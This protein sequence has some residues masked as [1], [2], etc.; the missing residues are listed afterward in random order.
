MAMKIRAALLGM[1]V[2][3]SIVLSATAHGWAQEKKKFSFKAPPGLGKYTQNHVIDVRD[4]PGHQ[5][6]IFELRTAYTDVAPEFDGVKVKEAWA[7]GFSDY[8]NGS[9]AATAYNV[10]LMENGDKIYSRT[11]I[12]SHTVTAADGS[13]QLTFRTVQTLTGGTGKFSGIRGVL[14]GGGSSDLKTA[15]VDSGTQGEYWIEK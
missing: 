6:R 2:T 15:V 14:L 5:I 1:I 13:R 3:A 12:H 4:V 7:H 8:I 10:S 9:G 11:A